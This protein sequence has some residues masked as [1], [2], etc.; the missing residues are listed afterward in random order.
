MQSKLL[1]QQCIKQ[2]AMDG[3]SMGETCIPTSDLPTKDKATCLHD[4]A[5]MQK[6]CAQPI[7]G[8]LDASYRLL[9]LIKSQVCSGLLKHSTQDSLLCLCKHTSSTYKQYHRML[10]RTTLAYC[11]YFGSDSKAHNITTECSRLFLRHL[12]HVLTDNRHVTQPS[13]ND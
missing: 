1:G 8:A 5:S 11:T 10:I 12:Q 6:H 7:M 3:S 9:A 4:E 2:T 13:G